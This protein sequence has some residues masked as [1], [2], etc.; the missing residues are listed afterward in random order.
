MDLSVAGQVVAVAAPIAVMMGGYLQ[1]RIDRTVGRVVDAKTETFMSRE[2]L[3]LRFT[4][5]DTHLELVNTH[6]TRLDSHMRRVGT[7][8][9]KFDSPRIMD[10]LQTISLRVEGIE[11][12]MRKED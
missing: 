6:L 3:D 2:V 4:A 7:T 9:E 10:R 8:F 12:A 1:W 5:V 11:R